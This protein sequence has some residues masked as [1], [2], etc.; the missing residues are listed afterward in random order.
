MPG[1]NTYPFDD[2]KWL[3]AEVVSLPEGKLEAQ[4]NRNMKVMDTVKPIGITESA[5]GV[6]ILDMGQNMVGWLLHENKGAIRRYVKTAFCRVV[7]ERRFYLYGKSANGT[8]GRYL[9]LKGK[10]YG[11]VANRLLLIM[12]FVLLN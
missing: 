11:R 5:P 10:F 6:Y 12:D 2:T 3:Q 8:F 4:L 9:Y 7:A 1:W